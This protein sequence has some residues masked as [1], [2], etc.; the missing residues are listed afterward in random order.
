MKFSFRSIKKIR[1]A[2]Q[3]NAKFEKDMIDA[4][5]Y[6]MKNAMKNAMNQKIY[7]RHH[8]GRWNTF[9]F[10]PH[11]IHDW[12]DPNHY[13]PDGSPKPKIDIIKTQVRM[14]QT[15][16]K[17]GL[18]TSQKMIALKFLAARYDAEI[19]NPIN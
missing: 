4:M 18:T 17:K 19:I 15:H 14:L 13:E 1:R 5:S 6:A 11:P 7:E 16:L 9:S 8:Q 10:E 3:E 2:A 12:W